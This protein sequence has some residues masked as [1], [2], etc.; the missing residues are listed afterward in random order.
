MIE[1]EIGMKFVAKNEISPE[2]SN[3][4]K[5]MDV[6]VL[7]KIIRQ[8]EFKYCFNRIMLNELHVCLSQQEIKDNF[9]RLDEWR[10]MQINEIL[11]D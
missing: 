4:L 9:Y 10:D 2:L 7:T 3:F 5:P 8:T 11:N 6:I 1:F